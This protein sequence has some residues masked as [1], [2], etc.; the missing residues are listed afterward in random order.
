MALTYIKIF[1]DCLDAIEPLDD[2]ERGRLFTALL[3]YARTGEATGLQGNER[4]LFPMLRAQL[5]REAAAY[6]EL[7]ETNRLKG[8]KGGRPRKNPEFFAETPKS[9]EE[10]KDKDKDKDQDKEKEKKEKE[11]SSCGA[12]RPAQRKYG[13]K[14]VFPPCRQSRPH[15]HSAE[16][17]GR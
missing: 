1:V 13:S 6:A 9:Q 17:D 14:S 2:G 16:K 7:C 5:D 3:Q 10:E 15:R 4:F 12:G 11:Y 8:M